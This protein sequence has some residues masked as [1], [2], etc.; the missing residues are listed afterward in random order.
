[1]LLGGGVLLL[2]CGDEERAAPVNVDTLDPITLSDDALA[3]AL[4]AALGEVD[5]LAPVS[6]HDIAKAR[7]IMS[8]TRVLVAREGDDSR[9]N[10]ALVELRRV[11][12]A[13]R[14]ESCDALLDLCRVRARDQLDRAAAT[15]VAQEIIDRFAD[16]PSQLSCVL[17]ARRVT[18]ALSEDVFGDFFAGREQAEAATL[19]AASVYGPPASAEGTFVRIVLGFDR[20]A[21]FREEQVAADDT[22][23]RRLLLS[24]DNAL[25][26]PSVPRAQP[27]GLAG[28]ARLRQEQGDSDA[29]VAFDIAED[30]R[31]QLHLLTDPFRVV[32]DFERGE[33]R[34]ARVANGPRPVRT[35][36]LDP[37]HGGVE[38]G[39]QYEDLKES[40]IAL[41]LAKRV[42]VGLRA[43]LPDVRVLL[44]REDDVQVSLPQRTAMANAVGADVF[45]SIHFNSAN[46]Y[47]QRGGVTTF[48]LDTNDQRQATRL[49]ARE[50]G[51]SEAAVTGLQRILANIHRE[52]QVTESRAL[53]RVVHE[54]T[55]AGGRTILRNLPNRGVKSEVFHVLVGATMPAILLEASF[56]T[57]RREAYALRTNEYRQALADGIT[58][59]L[60]RYVSGE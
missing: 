13:D 60:I 17:G 21:V 28:V 45:L 35:I 57:K 39:A 51:T 3:Q 25:V 44:T 48:V 4:G 55:L 47:V 6:T 41:D 56:L 58:A 36:V 10:A 40:E 1:M 29:R 43:R 32:I 27:V 34:R 30:T 33:R 5:P 31:W 50:N 23:P 9:L 7:K 19:T 20:V 42:A 52:E 12:R 59:G 38:T 2:S 8:L 18:S 53:A 24:F 54:S 14:P 37:G 22:L 49:A 26:A 46:E 16:E 11:S 15:E